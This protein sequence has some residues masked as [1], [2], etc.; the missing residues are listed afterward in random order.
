[1]IAVYSV[2]CGLTW[3]ADVA[4]FVGEADMETL[5]LGGVTD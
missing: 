1:M 5:V 3:V 4:L 2:P